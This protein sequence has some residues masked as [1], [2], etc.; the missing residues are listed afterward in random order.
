MDNSMK[1][2]TLF[3]AVLFCIFVSNCRA[4]QEPTTVFV[5]GTFGAIIGKI[6]H[7]FDVPYGLTPALIQGDKIY[8]GRIPYI[9]NEANA[10]KFPLTSSYLFG[11]S[12]SLSFQE[13]KKAA[14][15]LYNWLKKIDGPITIIGHSHGGNVALNLVQVA[16]ERGDTTFAIDTLILLAV[17]VQ[18]VTE[19]YVSSP[20]FKRVFSFYS[21][22]DFTQTMDPEGLYKE[23]GKSARLQ[24][25]I[26][27]RRT[28]KPHDRLVQVG[29]VLYNKRPSH[30]EFITRRFIRELPR[31]VT[32]LRPLADYV[33]DRGKESHFAFSIPR[34]RR[35]PYRVGL[36][37]NMLY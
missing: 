12:G 7:K 8:M 16:E 37:T 9:L 26:F 30:L 28:F 29:I 4:T 10:K 3:W 11:W 27:S 22:S 25:R 18:V 5:H 23:W 24:K 34:C 17:P 32:L 21:R 36:A 14:V 6:L 35:S 20:I 31:I 33:I 1:I 2:Y 19:H 15:D 13:R